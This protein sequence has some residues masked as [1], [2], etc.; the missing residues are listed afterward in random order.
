MRDTPGI[1][2]KL[3]SALG[4]AKVNV[5]A[6]AQGSSERNISWVVSAG[7]EGVALRTVHRAF[8]SPADELEPVRILVLGAGGVGGA[9]LD[10]LAGN[11]DD[12]MRPHGIQPVLV[13]ISNSRKAATD[14][15][16]LV[17]GRW[18]AHLEGGC[19]DPVGAFEAV[20]TGDPLV[21]VDCTASAAVSARYA[22]Y[23]RAGA[24]VVTAN[25]IPLSGPIEEYATLMRLRARGRPSPR[26]D[27]GGR[28]S[29]GADDRR[30]W[31]ERRH[32]HLS[33]GDA[34]GHSH[35]PDGR[36][37]PR[38]AVQFGGRGSPAK[39][40][41]RAGSEGGPGP[42][43]RGPKARHPGTDG[44]NPD[45][46]LRC[47][48]RADPPGA[49]SPAWLGPGV[50]RAALRARRR[51]GGADPG[52]GGAR[53]AARLPGAGGAGRGLRPPRGG[54]RGATRRAN[55]RNREPPRHPLS[56][57]RRSPHRDS[58]PRSGAR[59]H[60]GRAHDRLGGGRRA[61]CQPSRTGST[62]SFLASVTSFDFV[63]VGNRPPPVR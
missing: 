33:R 54:A 5:H 44:G 58:G 45:R 49:P 39:G 1:T 63:T 38:A 50:H 13:G 46:T 6:I 20:C 15:E 23:L 60:R 29:D 40:D 51:D 53:G 24:A 25:K 55:P 9:F 32:R 36:T 27:R 14:L 37:P 17:A 7:Q 26:D 2:G 61:G 11:G 57:V 41:L 4:A 22:E 47:R 30:A 12:A 34:V 48:R 19:G 28:P 8:F 21:V 3:F 59:G 56:M 52:G 18:R 42:S 43:G 35:L 31:A 62:A 16:G 10:Q